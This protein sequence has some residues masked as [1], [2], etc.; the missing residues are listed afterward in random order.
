MTT[1]T[2]SVMMFANC[3]ALVGGN[4]T[5]YNSSYKDKTYACIDSED[6]PGYFTDVADKQ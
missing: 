6:T 3:T 1:V 5:V 2:S 4:G